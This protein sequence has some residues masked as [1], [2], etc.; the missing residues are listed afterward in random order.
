MPRTA[1]FDRTRALE[2]AMKLFWSQG[3]TATSLPELLDAM[4]IA[5][6]SFYASFGDKRQLFVECL[7][8]FA[9]RTAADLEAP[10]GDACPTQL[11][12]DFFESTLFEAPPRRVA[13]GCMMVNT[14]LELHDVDDELSRQASQGLDRVEHAFEA[15][16]AAAMERGSFHSNLTPSQLAA[17]LMTVNQ[18][19]RVESRKRVTPAVLRESLGTSLALIGLAA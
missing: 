3:Y 2:S 12:I 15:L 9:E 4:G 1:E 18:G 19:L 17:Y 16:F 11:V 10:L 8:L 13:C 5:R 7:G 6:S 14:I